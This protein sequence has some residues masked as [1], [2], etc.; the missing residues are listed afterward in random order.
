[1]TVDK[2]AEL[3]YKHGIKLVDIRTRE[4]LRD[5][6]LIP[7][8]TNLPWRTGPY[9]EPN[10]RFNI[11]LAKLVSKDKPVLLIC[12]SGKR[13]VEAAISA[14]SS[15]FKQ[16]FNVLSGVEGQPDGWKHKDLPW[17]D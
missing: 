9:L 17:D 13:S 8:V 6:G 5:V 16:V 7:G 2:A 10:P 4:E 15:G 14:T 11:E 1:M 3:Y 12:R